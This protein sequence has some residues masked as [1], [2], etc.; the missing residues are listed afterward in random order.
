MDTIVDLNKSVQGI[1][2]EVVGENTANALDARK[3]VAMLK[4]KM[5]AK[6]EKKQFIRIH[7]ADSKHTYGEPPE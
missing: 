7:A 6:G 4:L 1:E 5:K 2:T 3:A